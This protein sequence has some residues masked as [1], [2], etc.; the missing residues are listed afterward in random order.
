MKTEFTKGKWFMN[1][2]H[3]FIDNKG[4]AITD[5]KNRLICEVSHDLTELTLGEY[6]ANAKLIAA[7]PDLLKACEYALRVTGF[8]VEISNRLKEAIKKATELC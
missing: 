6:Q 8:S 1:T 2:T 3:K 4:L 5:S 7:A